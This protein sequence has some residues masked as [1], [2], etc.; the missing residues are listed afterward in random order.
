MMKPKKVKY[1]TLQTKAD[2][3]MSQYIRQKWADD[4]GYC[5]CVACNLEFH[6]S[7]MDCGHFIPKKRSTILRYVEENVAPECRDCNRFNEDHLIGYTFWMIEMYGKEKI[8]ELRIEG[9]KTLSPS[10]KRTLAEEA[11]IYYSE[12]LKCLQV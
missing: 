3:V 2:T 11:L 12:K 8:Q 7:E 5:K 4:G 10:Q 6:W 1:S 9:R